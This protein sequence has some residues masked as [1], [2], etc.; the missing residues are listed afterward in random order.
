MNQAATPPRAT[1]R[2]AQFS[3]EEAVSNAV[4]QLPPLPGADREDRVRIVTLEAEY[5]GIMGGSR[6]VVTVERIEGGQT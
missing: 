2:S 3:L 5:G 1:G 6:L 4:N